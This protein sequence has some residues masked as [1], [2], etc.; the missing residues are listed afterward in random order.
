MSPSEAEGALG[1]IRPV[2]ARELGRLQEIEV[3]A[4]RAFADI[5]MP[6]I[7]RDEPLPVEELDRYRRAGLAWV[8]SDPGDCP[9]GYL[10]A[11]VVDAALHVEQVSVDPEWAHR[12]L[13]RALLERAAC[14]A[15][16]RGLPALT[17][18]TF[19]H[20]PWNA[21]YYER[22]G[23]RILQVQDWTPGLRAIREHEASL[24]LDRW[25]RV[26]MRR[27]LTTSPLG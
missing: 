14:E 18:T 26:C 27:D 20:V 9:V 13:G 8:V 12:R 19:E 21:P 2:A 11:E 10:I 7:A 1:R 4:G 24:G 15:Q 16:T 5:G 23:F 22:C 25:P 6:E 17:L 3:S